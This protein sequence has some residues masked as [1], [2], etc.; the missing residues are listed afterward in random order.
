MSWLSNAIHDVENAFNNF[1]SALPADG[2]KLLAYL[3]PV[4]QSEEAA[5]LN[6]LTTIGE[7]I[8]QAFLANGTVSNADRNTAVSQLE[9]AAKA[10]GL[11]VA[12]SVLSTAVGLIAAKLEAAAAA[13]KPA[14]TAAPAAIAPAT[15]VG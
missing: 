10:D 2:K 8:V 11:A 14:A 9:A 15:S 5:V 4:F 7:P 3:E 12:S 6:Q 1:F 13:N